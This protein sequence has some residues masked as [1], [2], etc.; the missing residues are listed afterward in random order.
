M[1]EA[2]ASSG[3]DAGRTLM[4]I[5]DVGSTGSKPKQRADTDDAGGGFLGLIHTVM[6][7]RQREASAPQSRSGARDGPAAAADPVQDGDLGADMKA[8]AEA[9]PQ[10]GEALRRLETLVRSGEIEPE[11]LADLSDEELSEL[12]AWLLEGAGGAFPPCGPEASVVS[13]EWLRELLDVFDDGR[14]VSSGNEQTH[15]GESPL[16]GAEQGDAGGEA[17]APTVK[18]KPVSAAPDSSGPSPVPEQTG[19]ADRLTEAVQ[20]ADASDSNPIQHSESGA[21]S[22]GIA[23][24]VSAAQPA[25]APGPLQGTAGEGAAVTPPV[26]RP[27]SGEGQPPAVSLARRLAQMLADLA[28]EAST[29][30]QPR[31]HRGLL[32]RLTG[33][34]ALS[35]SERRELASALLKQ[36][37]NAAENAADAVGKEQSPQSASD[38]LARLEGAGRK[39]L[40]KL[41]ASAASE[42]GLEETQWA[43]RRLA[44]LPAPVLKSLAVEVLRVEAPGLDPLAELRALA[45]R[46]HQRGLLP[47]GNGRSGRVSHGES[48]SSTQGTGSGSAQSPS[49]S[50]ALEKTLLHGQDSPQPQG[51]TGGGEDSTRAAT[52]IPSGGVARSEGKQGLAEAGAPHRMTPEGPAHLGASEEIFG[53]EPTS[54]GARTG[55]ATPT[56]G[57]GTEPADFL[58]REDPLASR[59]DGV[60]PAGAA[61]PGGAE[62][63][64]AGE[65]APGRYVNF[66]QNMERISEALRH[67]VRQGARTATLQLSP[68][69]L[70]SVRMQIAVR[71]GVVSA[72]VEADTAGARDLLGAG[73]QSL[74]SQLESQGLRVGEVT[75]DYQSVDADAR[76]T[77]GGFWQESYRRRHGGGRQTSENETESPEPPEPSHAGISSDGRVDMMA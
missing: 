77:P 74:R 48:G 54:T 24:G 16:Q 72:H 10:A 47:H 31:E 58:G 3:Q 8:L 66:Q 36:I 55:L 7:A 23:Q 61:R 17:T 64:G 5:L 35:E 38:L 46:F 19:A 34:D 33:L 57:A 42:A 30:A 76:D 41:L 29:E 26:A 39:A 71:N 20:A 70:G 11:D 1:S 65:S 27:Q 6:A 62:A 43:S 60:A 44:E 50:E 18:L 15:A 73:V 32:D 56:G 59:H 22:K 13:A 67:A 12:V 40:A 75:V 21:L 63:P 49:A 25:E 52:E 45:G 53:G 37:A 2:L 14:P 4:S 69:Q 28:S 51:M 68:P 9:P